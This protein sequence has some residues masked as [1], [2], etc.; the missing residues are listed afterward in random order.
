MGINNK[1]LLIFFVLLILINL[2]SA[3]G[4]TIGEITPK[5]L[6]EYED[7]TATMKVLISSVSSG[8]NCL[9]ECSWS[10][11]D[12][13]G[14]FDLNKNENYGLEFKSI[15]KPGTGKVTGTLTMTCTETW[16]ICGTDDS[17]PP[18]SFSHTY[19]FLGDNKCLPS[20]KEDCT[21][22]LS[23]CPCLTSDSSCINDKGDQNRILDERKCATYCGNGIKELTYE[24]C[25]SCPIDAGKCDLMNCIS[26]SE[27]EGSFCVHEVCWNKPYREGDNFC[28]IN[29][30]E[31]CKNSNDCA[32]KNDELC[33]NT[34]ICEKSETS[35]EE[36][37]DAVKSGVQET[38]EVSKS[39]QKNITIGAIVLIIL[40][41]IVYIAYK[42]LKGKKDSA[43]NK[44]KKEE[45]D[46]KT[47]IAELEK[48]IK[49]EQKNI[50]KIKRQ[51]K[52]KLKNEIF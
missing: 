28:D 42:L 26:G 7:G 38:L 5:I 3:T 19:P 15:A 22:S 44:N 17:A 52:N 13:S 46:K 31:N 23:D 2:I 16:G 34:G 49:E 4:F 20:T 35:K 25:S 50:Q 24:S 14:N 9:Q 8:G 6:A 27:C 45:F 37:T 51:G 33:S 32:C 18:K 10:T 39:R 1:F 21:K 29:Q 12:D 11:N 36:I 41:I 48:T 40:V 43:N 30:I 47:R